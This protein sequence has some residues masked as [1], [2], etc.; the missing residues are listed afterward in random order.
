M[1]MSAS[2]LFDEL[3]ESGGAVAAFNA[4]TIEHAEAI[5]T[6]A[7]QA[8]QP[9]I[10][11]L[12]QNAIGFHGRPEGIAAAMAAVANSS[13]ARIVLHLDHITDVDLA[14]RTRELGFSSVM[15]DGATQEYA[16]N[17]AAT[18]RVA[19]WGAEQGVWVEAELGEIGGKDGAHA[20]GVRTDPQEAAEFVA[21][22]G[23]DSLAV[24]VGSSHAMTT[25]SATL[26]IELIRAIAERVDVPLVLHGSSGVPDDTLAEAARAG[27]RKINIGTALNI[28]FTGAVRSWLDEN[29]GVDPR[30]YLAPGREAMAQTCRH[31]LEVVSGR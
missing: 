26:D 12:S 11:Q 1:L 14:L 28:A 13:T 17:V 29:D 4:I 18:R 25:R 24:A 5:A 22:T 27:M 16:A 8:D 30:R 31:Y 6:A 7:E 3:R 20:P 9:V 10:M 19:T 2:D 15:F 23:V 21:S